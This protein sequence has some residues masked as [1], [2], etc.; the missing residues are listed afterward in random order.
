MNDIATIDPRTVDWTNVVASS[1]R[2]T[3]TFRYDYAEPITH[4]RHRLVVSPRE[5]HGDQRR[6]SHDVRVSP[7]LPTRLQTDVFGNDIVAL[8]ADRV[9]RHIAFTLDCLVTRD[10]RTGVHVVDDSHAEQPAYRERR[11][12]THADAALADAGADLRRRHADAHER[13]HAISDFVYGA[14]TYTKDATDVFTTAAQAFA[15]RRGVCQDYAHVMI[16]IARASGLTARYVSGHLLGEGATHAWVEIFVPQ[17]LATRVVALDPTHGCGVDLR[18]VVIA[19]G[20][21]YEDVAPT[22]G[23][24]TGR[25]AGTLSAEQRVDVTRV[26]AA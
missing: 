4:L 20:R 23:I 25:A 26:I 10:R 12:L 21:D 18:Y 15:A 24:Y 19:V 13:A 7:D 1:Y 5:R 2:I 14:M 22:S 16:A 11:R 17:G 8:H 9:D 6:V 3:Q